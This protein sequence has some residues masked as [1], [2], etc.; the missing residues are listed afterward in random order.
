MFFNIIGSFDWNRLES[1]AE[2]GKEGERENSELCSLRLPP[3]TDFMSKTYERLTRNEGTNAEL[4]LYS[5]VAFSVSLST[6]F[7]VFLSCVLLLH[8]K[9]S[10]P[11]LIWERSMNNEHIAS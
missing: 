5:G 4:E 11:H 9:S 2:E 10:R 8:E 3:I 6:F 1:S 7:Q